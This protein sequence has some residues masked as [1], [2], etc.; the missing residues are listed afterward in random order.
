[1]KAAHATPINAE[2]CH[3]DAPLLVTLYMQSQGRGVRR[4][5]TLKAV[6]ISITLAKYLSRTQ[7]STLKKTP[8]LAE[9]WFVE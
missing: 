2:R 6:R 1:M 3:H 8:K 7:T 9:L 5:G 4:E